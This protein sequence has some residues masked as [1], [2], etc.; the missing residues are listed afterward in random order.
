MKRWSNNCQ[1]VS[2]DEE[3]NTQLARHTRS[4]RASK[5][6]R[7]ILPN[8]ILPDD[9]DDEFVDRYHNMIPNGKPANKYFRQV[10]RKLHL[11]KQTLSPARG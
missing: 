5:P 3:K 8:A 11:R 10:L 4:A 6:I 7:F 9:S 1:Q 2:N